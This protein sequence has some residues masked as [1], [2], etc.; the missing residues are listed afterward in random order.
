VLVEVRERRAWA[1]TP[2]AAVT[3]LHHANGVLGAHVLM[4]RATSDFERRR[5]VL[6]ASAI[7]RRRCFGTQSERGNLFAERL[8][9][10]AHTARKQRKDVLAFRRNPSAK[11]IGSDIPS[12]P[13]R[14]VIS[15]PSSVSRS[16]WSPSS[17]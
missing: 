10:V 6:N 16:T 17:G 5:N 4:P 8:M 2:R 9:T 15:L 14:S 12:G 13:R 7:P 1:F 3:K 11:R